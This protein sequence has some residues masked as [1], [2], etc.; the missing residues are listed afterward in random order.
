MILGS[1]VTAGDR[2]LQKYLNGEALADAECIA[3]QAAMATMSVDDAEDLTFQ[4]FDALEAKTQ[5]GEADDDEELSRLRASVPRARESRERREAW[6][7]T[8]RPRLLWARLWKTAIGA[9]QQRR[10][11]EPCCRPNRARNRC[12]RGQTARRRRAT[13]AG[14][15]DGSSDGPGGDPEGDASPIAPALGRG[16]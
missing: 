15:D 10:G 13:C 16:R 8:Q 14:R 3:L 5:V 2:A 1:A 11:L 4:R 9:R 12:S 7:R 6:D